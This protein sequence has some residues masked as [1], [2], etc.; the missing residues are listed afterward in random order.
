MG[1]HGEFEAAIR[2]LETIHL[3][4]TADTQLNLFE[5]TIRYLGGLLGAYDVS[6]A[7]YAVLLEKARQPG[8]MLYAAFDTANRMPVTRWNP[9]LAAQGNAREPAETVL[10]SE[11]TSLSLEFTR[12]SQHT[13]DDKY[14]DAIQRISNELE[15]AQGLTRLP[16]MWPIAGI[17]QNMPFSNDKH[18]IFG[19]MP[20]SLYE[21]LLKVGRWK[22]PTCHCLTQRRSTCLLVARYLNSS[23]CTKDCCKL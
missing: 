3:A 7:K 13:N 11:L 12:L 18:F 22:L 21:Y 19:G 8:D 1:L 17:A 5:T 9:Q 2:A 20:D 10:V 15:R 6:D 16:G 23:F 14:C 4:Y